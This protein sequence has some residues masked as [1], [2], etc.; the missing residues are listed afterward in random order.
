MKK[1]FRKKFFTLKNSKMI[2]RI[3]E[4]QLTNTK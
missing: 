3:N 2:F 4:M 1:K